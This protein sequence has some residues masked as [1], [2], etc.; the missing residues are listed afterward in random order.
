MPFIKEWIR[1]TFV[2]YPRLHRVLSEKPAWAPS[3]QKMRRASIQGPPKR[4]IADSATILDISSS[5]AYKSKPNQAT[6]ATAK[7][8]QP[9][10]Q[11]SQ[12]TKYTTTPERRLSWKLTLQG[13]CQ[14]CNY[15]QLDKKVL[16]RGLTNFCQ[17]FSFQALTKR[18]NSERLWAA[19]KNNWTIN[20]SINNMIVGRPRLHGSVEYYSNRPW[21]DASAKSPNTKHDWASR[22]NAYT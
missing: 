19:Q 17:S 3:V 16:Y 14:K 1:R 22:S 8:A 21:C 4:P 18:I 12:Y 2:G 13:A 6:Q 11:A 10:I 7:S 20:Q 9:P 5:P 15:C